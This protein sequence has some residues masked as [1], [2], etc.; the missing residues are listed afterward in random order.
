MRAVC[1]PGRGRAGLAPGSRDF[2]PAPQHTARGTEH[3]LP[4]KRRVTAEGRSFGVLHGDALAQPEA[5]ATAHR[6]LHVPVCQRITDLITVVQGQRQDPGFWSPGTDSGS[7]LPP[8]VSLL[9]SQ[10]RPSWLLPQPMLRPPLTPGSWDGERTLCALSCGCVQRNQGR[11][12]DGSRSR[13]ARPG[14][15]RAA[16]FWLCT[17]A[18]GLQGQR[19][20][21]RT[22]LHGEAH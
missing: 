14:A 2:P 11:F 6:W 15:A 5:A 16:G 13:A 3:T 20:R 21:T 8:G 7:V 18:D 17:A 10:L 4:R 22:G 12:K 9:G 19:S 1:G